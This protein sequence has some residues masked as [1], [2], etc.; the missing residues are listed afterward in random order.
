MARI[1][2]TTLG[3]SLILTAMFE[4]T[5]QIRRVYGKVIKSGQLTSQVT[6]FF[7]IGIFSGNYRLIFRWRHFYHYGDTVRHYDCLDRR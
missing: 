3:Y 6:N 2:S 7:E 1:W 4:R 5:W